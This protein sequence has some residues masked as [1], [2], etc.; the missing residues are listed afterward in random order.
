MIDLLRGESKE[1]RSNMRSTHEWQ[2]EIRRL[3]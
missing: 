2:V 1:I 3:T